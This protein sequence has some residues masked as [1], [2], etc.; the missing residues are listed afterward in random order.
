M[1]RITRVALEN[2][3]SF[4]HMVPSYA[5]EN[6]DAEMLEQVMER[7]PGVQNVYFHRK[8]MSKPRLRELR[9]LCET[10]GL[11]PVSSNDIP[12]R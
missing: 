6:I 10:V 2:K 9:E 11:Q 12:L 5:L 7:T 4:G 1:P 3:M 8:G